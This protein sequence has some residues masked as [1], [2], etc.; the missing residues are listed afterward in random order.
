[1]I[2]SDCLASHLHYCP[3]LPSR[4]SAGPMVAIVLAIFLMTVVRISFLSII[5]STRMEPAMETSHIAR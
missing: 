4:A 1:M 3:L 2:L 5:V